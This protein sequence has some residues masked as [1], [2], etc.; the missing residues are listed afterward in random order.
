MSNITM[1]ILGL[2]G[3]M[4]LF[5]DAPERVKQLYDEAV[6]TGQQLAT[7]GDMRSMS[8]MLD[9]HYL[10]NGRC[11]KPE[12]FDQWLAVTFKSSVDRDLAIDHWGTP[13]F[14]DTDDDLNR[15]SLISAG[16]DRTLGT[17]DDMRID[18]P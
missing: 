5:T 13:F 12:R 14:Y 16:P 2:A 17:A 8:N 4:L 10:K 15:Y 3:A 6:L 7:A 9:Y 11:P 18:G 1:A